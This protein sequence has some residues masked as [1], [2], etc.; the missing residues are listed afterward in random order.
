MKRTDATFW[1]GTGILRS[2]G[3]AF[4]AAPPR[5]VQI[6]TAREQASSNARG[7]R[8]A[9]A[10]LAQPKNAITIGKQA[11]SDKRARLRRANI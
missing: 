10:I 5:A 6:G 8:P 1:P 11:D 4:T 9:S 3:N 7:R 2:T